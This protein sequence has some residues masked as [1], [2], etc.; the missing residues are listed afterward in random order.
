[1]KEIINSIT[2]FLLTTFVFLLGEIDI[3]LV[4]LL[5]VMTLDYITGVLSAFYNKELS[6]KVGFKGLLKKFLYLV[7]IALSVRID[8]LMG[9]SE[10]IRTFVIYYF[11]ANDGLSIVE[12]AG[13][14]GIKLPK[15]L[16]DALEQLKDKG[17]K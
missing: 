12:N 17:D 2:S 16:I 9:S 11:V 5:I 6:S 8:N 14:I 15:K 4:S 1:M 3:A 10:L 13:E 7:I